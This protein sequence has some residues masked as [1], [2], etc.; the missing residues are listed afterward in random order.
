MLKTNALIEIK[1]NV[2][3][4]YIHAKWSRMFDSKDIFEDILV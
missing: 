4:A 1:D 2:F 3:L